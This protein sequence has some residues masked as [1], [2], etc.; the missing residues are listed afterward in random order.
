MAEAQAAVC[1][2]DFEDNNIKLCAQLR[3]LR[4]ML[5]FLRPREVRDVHETINAFFQFNEYAE[6]GEVAYL[7]LVLRANG[8]FLFD[9]LPRIFFELLDAERHLA[10]LA[11]ERKDYSLNFVAY[12]EEVLR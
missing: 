9:V 11:V 8:I 1:L 2:V 10:L 7:A 6:V 3:E 5:N 4:R 12:L